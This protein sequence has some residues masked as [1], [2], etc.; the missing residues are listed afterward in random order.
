MEK[1][2]KNLLLLFCVMFLSLSLIGAI[3]LQFL[4]TYSFLHNFLLSLRAVSLNGGSFQSI[5]SIADYTGFILLALIQCGALLWLFFSLQFANIIG[6]SALFHNHGETE[7]TVLPAKTIFRKA[8]INIVLLEAFSALALYAFSKNLSA[9]EPF[10][11]SVFN[12]ISIV[13][14]AGFSFNLY[15]T[16]FNE[17][18][19]FQFVIAGLLIVSRLGY[20]VFFDLTNLNRL[21]E[22]MLHPEKNWTLQTRVSF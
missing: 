9:D 15:S 3:A 12:S 8:L 21:R 4:G 19:I 10:F 16:A 20:P 1:R 7:N 14:H 13:S 5:I 2:L 6:Q 17:A 11:W 22:R 18:Y